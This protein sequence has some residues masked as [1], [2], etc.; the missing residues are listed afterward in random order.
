MICYF[1][2]WCV[3][4]LFTL[5]SLIYWAQT[6][7]NY[8]ISHQV[9]F[10]YGVQDAHQFLKNCHYS[11]IMYPSWGFATVLLVIAVRDSASKMYYNHATRKLWFS[12]WRTRLLSVK[13]LQM[14]CICSIFLLAKFR[15]RVRNNKLNIYRFLLVLFENYIKSGHQII[16]NDH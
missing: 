15:K 8:S 5:C 14:L 4:C 11:L 12:R 3:F 1:I 6:Y 2:S 7:L 13:S 16:I 10:Q 9:R